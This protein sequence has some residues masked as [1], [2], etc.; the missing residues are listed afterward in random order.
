MAISYTDEM[1]R[2]APRIQ[3]DGMVI[4]ADWASGCSQFFKGRFIEAHT[5]L[6]R[7]P[8]LYDR[9][10]HPALAVQF[11]QGPCVSCDWFDAITLLML[12]YRVLAEEQAQGCMRH[13][14]GVGKQV[15]VT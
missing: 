12:G 10:R 1:T 3:K 13:A 7:A 4:Q 5:R 11:G 6:G 15:T 14:G 8:G 9:Q 2:L